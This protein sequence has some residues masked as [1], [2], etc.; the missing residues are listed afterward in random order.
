MTATLNYWGA[1]TCAA[2]SG[3]IYDGNDAPPRGVL[4]YAPS[5]YAPAPLTQLS[6]PTN[7]GIIT[8]TSTVTLTWTPIPAVPNIGCRNPG[9]STPDWGYRI[10]YDNDS[11]PPY[12]G[13]GLP[14]GN[15]P[16]TAGQDATFVLNGLAGGE[17]HFVVA[18]YDYLGRESTYSN[19][20]VRPSDYRKVYLPIILKA[21]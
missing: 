10:Y 3:R 2:I 7:L 6:S 19:E 8:G 16:I 15:S 12:Q 20:V 1:L 13:T 18:A 4:R 21:S 11:C 5:V 17:Y 14:Q 9:P